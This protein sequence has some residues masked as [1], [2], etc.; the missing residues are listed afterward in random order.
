MSH[1]SKPITVAVSGG[2]DPVHIGHL[3][4]FDEAKKLGT[5]LI[6]ILNNDNWL[7]QKKGLVFM[8]Q[9]QRKELIEG[10]RSVDQVVLTGHPENPTDM[11]VC[12]KMVFNIGAQGKVQSS[13]WLL[14][15]YA[16][17]LKQHSD[18]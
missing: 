15:N 9:E 4:M 1:E 18:S 6:V 2:F 8:P 10:F 3:R 5:K 16:K 12:R 14:E 11:S 17:N 13:S 7:R